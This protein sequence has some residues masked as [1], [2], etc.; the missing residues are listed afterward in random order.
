MKDVTYHDRYLGTLVAT[1]DGRWEAWFGGDPSTWGAFALGVFA[2]P[3]DGA[4]ALLVR[5]RVNSM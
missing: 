5:F 3:E 1:D 2:T 4:T